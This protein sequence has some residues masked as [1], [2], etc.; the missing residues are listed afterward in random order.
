MEFA[1]INVKLN[2]TSLKL[3]IA[4]EQDDMCLSL[5]DVGQRQYVVISLSLGGVNL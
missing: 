4:V 3:R 1:K 5:S 2:N